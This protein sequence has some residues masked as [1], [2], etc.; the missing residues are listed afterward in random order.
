MKEFRKIDYSEYKDKYDENI[1]EKLHTSP[2]D[3]DIEAMRAYIYGYT[4]TEQY[5]RCIFPDELSMD[6]WSDECGDELDDELERINNMSLDDIKKEM[7]DALEN[8]T[9]DMYDV[10]TVQERLILEA[11]DSTGDGESPETALCVIDVD[12]EYEYLH[13]V[14]P[15]YVLSMFRQSVK[16]GI[17]CLE[18]EPNIYGVERIYFDVKRRFDVGYPSFNEE[19]D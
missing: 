3:I 17:D 4:F 15:F 18:F 6:Y 11:I 14:F 13:R 5:A 9:I 19:N 7:M 2:K 8:D 1:K 16:D 10:S 12:Q